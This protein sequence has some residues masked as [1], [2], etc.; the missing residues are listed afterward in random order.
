MISFLMY[1]Y[2]DIYVIPAAAVAW[3]LLVPR[4]F[5]AFCDPLFGWLVDRTGGRYVLRTMRWL[6]V[7][8]GVLAFFCF[9]PL[10]LTGTARIVWASATYLALGAVYSAINTPY[11]ALSNMMAVTTS[12]QVSL[13]SFRIAGCQLGQLLIAGATLPALAWAGGGTSLGAQ[14]LGMARVAAVIGAVSAVLW[15]FTARTCKVRRPL[16]LE[17]H[18][19][20]RLGGALV[21][22]RRFHLANA[23]TYLNFTTFC[24]QGGLA[25]HYTRMVM[26]HTTAEAAWVLSCMTV[27]AFLGVLVL[28]P[29]AQR[30]GV[31]R[32]YLG[33]IAWEVASLLVMLAA[34]QNFPLFLAA[35]FAQYLG[36]G[37]VSPLCL[38][39]LSEAIDKG[40]A[41]TGVAAAG[42]AFATNTLTS[43]I[44]AGVAGFAIATFLALGHY[45]PRLAAASTQLQLWLKIGFIG[46]PLAS[47]TI[48]AILVGCS[49]REASPAPPALAAIPIAH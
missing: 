12:E 31:R 9:L 5:D 4:V 44:A 16:P 2:T 1:Y 25:I 43:K 39:I 19:L 37:P 34:G 17:R 21:G 10:P 7:L 41:E 36:N 26:H 49:R 42:L 27:A 15:I 30:F 45:D 35:V 11:G 23:L 33:V 20:R 32:T 14:Q 28:P 6:A 38:V 29:L 22:N 13:N 18:S 3:L 48:A 24:A 46:L 40:R 47:L 8:F